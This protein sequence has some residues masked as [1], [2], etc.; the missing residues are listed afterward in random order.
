MLDENLEEF[1]R[2]FGQ[3]TSQRFPT[4]SEVEQYR[5]ILPDRLLEYWQEIGFSG[6]MDG[7]FW[8]VNPADYDDVVERFLESTDFPEL[9]TYHV[10][11]R[12]AWGK[13][14]LWGKKQGIH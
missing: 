14:H 3:P 6:Y 11:A 5:G 12:N 4:A 8:I 7:L 10:I 2:E 9:D 1:L 13:L